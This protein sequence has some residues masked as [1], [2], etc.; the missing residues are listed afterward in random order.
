M[1]TLSL[2]SR[3]LAYEDVG[4]TNN[5]EQRPFDWTRKI[6]SIPVENPATEPHRIAPLQS[7]TLFTGVRTLTADNTT[8]Y[9]LSVSPLAANRYR[10]KWD[11]TGTA[12][13]FRTARTID[14]AAGTVTVTPQLN[15]SVVVTASAGLI[16]GSVQDGDTVFIPGVSTGDAAGPFDTLNE[17]FWFVLSATSAQVVL[18]R[19]PGTVFSAKGETVAVASNTAVQ[20]FSSTGVLVDDILKLS[21]AF[22]AALRQS[23]EIVAITDSFIEFL[24]GVTLAPLSNAIPGATAVTIYSNAKSWIYLE[25]DQNLDIT[26][27]GNTAFA[28]EPLVAGDPTKI[29]RFELMGTIYSLAVA[30]AS[31]Q[32]ATIRVLSAE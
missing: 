20:A 29:G 1:P 27:N 6:Q 14:F 12:P 21:S 2:T 16:F 4:A 25:T 18:A 15:Q 5:P 26:I 13:G 28:V 9:D 3:F 30:N 17:G 10:L 31:A 8:Q 7:A 22:P 11:G 32:T 19:S 24:S 23:Y